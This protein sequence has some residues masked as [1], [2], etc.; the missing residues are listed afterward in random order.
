MEKEKN[1]YRAW[2]GG[3]TCYTYLKL[4]KG[5]DPSLLE[6]QIMD[7]MEGVIN[8]KYREFGYLVIPYL[9][10]IGDI[11]LDLKT[12]SDMGE[13]GSRM[14]VIGFSGIGLLILLIACFNFVNISTALSFRRTKE[15]SIKKIFGSGRKNIILFFVFESA[16][17]I[18]VSLLLAFLLAKVLLPSAS[19]FVGKVLT[20]TDIKPF[21]WLLIYA[22]LFLFCT[23][24]ASFYSS[25]YLSSISP[26]ALLGSTSTMEEGNK[27]HEISL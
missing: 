23:I 16:V 9:Q 11:H 4:I 8:K 5:A 26:L 3:L 21:G 17:A 10:N 15:V 24:F 7:Y 13:V 1:S 19:E 14:Q 20:L 22:S 25:F 2:D 27:V 18:I 12:E 6:K